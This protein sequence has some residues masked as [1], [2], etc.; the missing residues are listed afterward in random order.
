M[1]IIYFEMKFKCFCKQFVC[2]YVFFCVNFYICL[3]NVFVLIDYVFDVFK[4]I[5][6]LVYCCVILFQFYGLE[7]CLVDVVCFFLFIW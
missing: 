2:E 5:F 1:E 3:E 4:V 7:I 6:S